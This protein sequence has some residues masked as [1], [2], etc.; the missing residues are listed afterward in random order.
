M[1]LLT[2]SPGC[3]LLKM[4]GSARSIPPPHPLIRSHI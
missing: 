1:K 4:T 2:L 3:T